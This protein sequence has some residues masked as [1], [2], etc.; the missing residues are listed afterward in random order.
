MIEI[1]KYFAIVYMIIIIKLPLVGVDVP[2]LPI[3]DSGK[4]HLFTVAVVVEEVVVEVF[5]VVLVDIVDVIFF[6]VVIDVLAIAE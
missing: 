5:V 6:V 3:S 2:H 1:R 4:L